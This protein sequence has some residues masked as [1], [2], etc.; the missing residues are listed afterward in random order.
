[1]IRFG[2]HILKILAFAAVV[3]IIG[4][5]PVR[6]RRI[7]DHVRDVVTHHFVQKPVRWISSTFNFLEGHKAVHADAVSRDAR[8]ADSP[9]HNES[10]RSRLSGLLKSRQ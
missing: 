9:E 8:R 4:Q 2:L 1:M 5:I 3:L 7:C 6:G 10:D